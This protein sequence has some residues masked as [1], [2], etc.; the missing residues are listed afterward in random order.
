[1]PSGAVGDRPRDVERVRA[2]DLVVDDAQRLELVVAQDRLVEDELVG[3]LGRLGEQVALA[4]DA[5]RRAT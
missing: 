3:V 5:G 1:M 2:E 4:A